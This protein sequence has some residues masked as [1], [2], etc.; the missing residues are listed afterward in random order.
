MLR[1]AFDEAQGG[2]D[3]DTTLTQYADMVYD[4]LPPAGRP[5]CRVCQGK[6]KIRKPTTFGVYIKTGAVAYMANCRYCDGTGKGPI[7]E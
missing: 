2:L 4:A 6:G 1:E 7:R 5:Q 3:Y